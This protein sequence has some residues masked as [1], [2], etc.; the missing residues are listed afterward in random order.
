MLNKQAVDRPL[1]VPESKFGVWFLGTETWDTRVL[2]IAMN[3]LKGLIANRKESYP[4]IVD[5]G[6]GQGRSFQRLCDYFAPNHLIG[7]DID[8]D[9]LRRA[10]VETNGLGCRASLI[11]GTSSDLA[12]A[13]QSADMVFCHQ[14]MHHLID[15]DGAIRE[16]YRILKPGGLLLFAESTRA[17]IH[18][19]IIRLFFRHPMDMQ[20]S[21]DEYIRLVRN[22]GFDVAP[23]SISYPY[24]WW[25]RLDLGILEHWFSRAPASD[26]EETLINIIAVKGSRPEDQTE[27][28]E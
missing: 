22:A 10:A 7:V 16:F 20:K 24:L 3:D 4:V 19:W 28:T 21:A 15:Q 12:L 18:S 27:E 13:D 17:F 6:C 9:M 1:H 8:S 23:E 14:T 5:V 26:R 25:S 2:G 11:H